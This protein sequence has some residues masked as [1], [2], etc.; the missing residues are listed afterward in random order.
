MLIFSILR[1]CGLHGQIKK[2]VLN[3]SANV[4]INQFQDL[5]DNELLEADFQKIKEQLDLQ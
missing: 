5:I 4:I 3:K 2:Y 1:S